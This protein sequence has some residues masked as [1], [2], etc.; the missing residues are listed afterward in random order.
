MF[1]I[2]NLS[3]YCYHFLGGMFGCMFISV[4]DIIKYMLLFRHSITETSFV[5]VINIFTIYF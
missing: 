4:H 3:D 1:H 5:F 2:S